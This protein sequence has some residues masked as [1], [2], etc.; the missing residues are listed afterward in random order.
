MVVIYFSREKKELKI[1]SRSQES[2]VYTFSKTTPT[3]ASSLRNV[4]HI[5]TDKGTEQY[6][7]LARNSRLSGPL[8]EA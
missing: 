5:V 8:C 6:K 7:L 2:C 3:H 1:V 4:F